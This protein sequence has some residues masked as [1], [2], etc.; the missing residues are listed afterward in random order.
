M[1]TLT[2]ICL[3]T[4]LSLKVNAQ[5]DLK[6]KIRELEQQEVQA[7]LDRD[8]T[9]LAKVWHTDMMVN[10]PYNMIILKREEVFNRIHSG[11]IN[12]SSFTREVEEI[13]IYDDFIVSM[14]HETLAQKTSNVKQTRRYTNIWRQYEGQWKIAVRHANVICE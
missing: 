11:V 12:Y 4:L 3:L 8:L 10:N 13:M 1:K 7:V 5:E 6:Q 2:L 14:G 9:A